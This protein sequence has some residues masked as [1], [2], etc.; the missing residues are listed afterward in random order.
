MLTAKQLQTYK[1]IC[2][3]LRKNKIAPTTAEVAA[4]IGITSRGVVHRYLSALQEAGYIS[5]VPGKRRNIQLLE[6]DDVHLELPIIGKIAA[7][8]PIQAIETERELNIGEA[9]LGKGR[10]ILQVKGD[11]MIGDNIVDG[12]YIVC[13]SIQVAHPNDIVVALIENSEATL[14]RIHTN[15]DGTVTLI[16]SNPKLSPLVYPAQ[17]VQIQGRYLG[18]LRMA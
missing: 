6:N 13:E 12:D 18:L 7:G 17:D 15:K 4:G 14:K 5:L 10:F 16:P 9:F 8:S 3:Y 11:S 1:F 2:D